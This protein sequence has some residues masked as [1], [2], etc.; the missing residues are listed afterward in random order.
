M[1]GFIRKAKDVVTRKLHLGGGEDV[2]RDEYYDD[3][4]DYEYQDPASYEDSPRETY[5]ESYKDSHKDDPMQDHY[6]R[7]GAAR[8]VPDKTDKARTYK[9]KIVALGYS[10]PNGAGP[11]VV[12]A[13]PNQLPPAAVIAHPKDIKDAAKLC[14]EICEGKMVIVDLSALDSVNAQRIAD[15]LGGVVHTIKGTTNRVNKG[16]FAISPR[17]YEVTF[18]KL[19]D[20]PPPREKDFSFFRSAAR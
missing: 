18:A 5:K 9:D 7:G 1:L 20:V 11:S 4:D 6:S 10:G 14:D 3:Y 13:M 2:Y 16:I 12:P 8:R 15:Y 17:E 19:E